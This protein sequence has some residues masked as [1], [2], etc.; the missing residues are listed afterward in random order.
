MRRYPP[1]RPASVRLW[2][3][4]QG[5]LTL[6]TQMSFF[7]ELTNVRWWCPPHLTHFRTSHGSLGFSCGR[8]T[9]TTS[10]VSWSAWSSEA[11]RGQRDCL[12][13]IMSNDSLRF[14][15]FDSRSG[16]PHG[17]VREW[18]P[19]CL[20]RG[21]LLSTS[22]VFAWS[23]GGTTNALSLQKGSRVCFFRFPFQFGVPRP[24]SF[25]SNNA[26]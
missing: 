14:F 12:S 26:A 23:S 7:H 13:L 16:T 6:S 18:P 4:D 10:V 17:K 15:S 25:R 24:A 21:L 8:S 20:W 9:G 5:A 11:R 3:N 2:S 1:G 22:S 19:Q